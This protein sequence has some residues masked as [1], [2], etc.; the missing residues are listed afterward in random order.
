MARDREYYLAIIIIYL[1]RCNNNIYYIF[2]DDTLERTCA[3][4]AGVFQHCNGAVIKKKKQVG[5]KKVRK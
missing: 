4:T 2:G 3:E 5:S 1:L